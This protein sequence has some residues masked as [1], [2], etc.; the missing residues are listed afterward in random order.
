MCLLIVIMWVVRIIIIVM[1]LKLK[2]KWDIVIGKYSY[3]IVVRS[4]LGNCFI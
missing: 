3:G 4:I 1:L 2:L